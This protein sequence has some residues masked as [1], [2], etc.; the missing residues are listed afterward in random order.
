MLKSPCFLRRVK[1]QF[2][3]NFPRFH[4]RHNKF[5][6]QL[7]PK[8]YF[9]S[10]S[11]VWTQRGVNYG[12]FKWLNVKL[13]NITYLI[14][15]FFLTRYFWKKH[16]LTN[17]MS[18]LFVDVFV[19][20]CQFPKITPA[21]YALQSWIVRIKCPCFEFIWS[22]FSRIWTKYGEI[23]RCSVQMREN[24]YQRNSKYRHFS[25]SETL[26]CFITSTILFNTLLFTHLP[27]QL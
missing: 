20:N 19:V 18:N 9:Y 14:F 15:F 10:Y 5:F 27:L 2:L 16:C 21:R 26:A 13:F 22:V 17:K 12:F 3:F 1:F 8:C 23:L 4:Q 11:V 25:R 24:T 7:K 6:K